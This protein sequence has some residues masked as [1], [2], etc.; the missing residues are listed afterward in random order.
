MPQYPKSFGS[1]NF[2]IKKNIF[3]E[4]NGFDENYKN[5]SGEDNDL[6]YKIGNAGY[7]IYFNKEMLVKHHHPE[8]VWKY[9]KEQ[10]Q[11][12]FWRAKMYKDH[13]CMIMG[14]DYTYW[15][16]ISSDVFGAAQLEADGITAAART[17]T[18]GIY[19]IDTPTTVL[20]YMIKIVAECDN[21]TQDNEFDIRIKKSS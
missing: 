19:F 14:D 3:D 12:G 6:S 20:K 10:Y 8:K 18:Q 4:V 5:A 16:D 15:K 11:H 7:K 21:G 1:Y 13:P 17:V 2:C 9:L